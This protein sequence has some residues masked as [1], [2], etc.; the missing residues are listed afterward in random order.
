VAESLEELLG[1]FLRKRRGERTYAD[2]ARRLGLPQSTLHR[3]EQGA[4]SIT[5]RRLQIIMK[6]LSCSLEDIFPAHYAAQDGARS[7][8][9]GE[10]AKRRAARK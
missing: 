7:G 1:A 6:R 9:K 10:A 5:L 8:D 2:F 4:Q 3:L